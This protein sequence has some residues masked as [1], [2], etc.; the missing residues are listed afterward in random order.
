MP[1]TEGWTSHKPSQGIRAHTHVQGV[2]QGLS[3][4]PGPVGKGVREFGADVVVVTLEELVQQ[5][6]L[7]EDISQLLPPFQGQPGTGNEGKR[8]VRWDFTA[9]ENNL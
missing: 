8:R 1:R 7:P 3:G 6:L 9:P 5:I 4:H 2:Q